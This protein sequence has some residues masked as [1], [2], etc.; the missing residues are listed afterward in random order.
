M[1]KEYS[2]TRGID[3]SKINL[4]P[5]SEQRNIVEFLSHIDKIQ[6]L[7]VI[8][9]LSDHHSK[10][11][12]WEFNTNIGKE[13]KEESCLTTLEIGKSLFNRN[14]E[15]TIIE[16][17]SD[18]TKTELFL[19]K[20][21]IYLDI[22]LNKYPRAAFFEHTSGDNHDPYHDF[23]SNTG[24]I[25]IIN[26]Y[27]PEL[28]S[29]STIIFLNNFLE[30]VLS[31]LNVYISSPKKGTEPIITANLPNNTT[32]RTIILEQLKNIAKIDKQRQFYRD[33]RHHDEYIRDLYGIDATLKYIESLS[34]HR[35][36]DVGA[37][38]GVAI[39]AIA[40][41]HPKLDF[42]ATNLTVNPQLIT[43]LSKDKVTITP[44][45]VMKGF[46]P[47]S[48]AGIIA[49]ASIAY[50]VSPE[51]IVQKF[52]EILVPGGV[53]KATFR[54]PQLSAMKEFGFQ[55]NETFA[56]Y[57]KEVGFDVQLIEK[58]ILI[59]I[60]PENTPKITA[61]K[62]A[63]E[64]YQSYINSGLKNTWTST[65]GDGS[66]IYNIIYPHGRGY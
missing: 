55:T 26:S 58:R 65:C 63:K 20:K 11:Y 64:D 16:K 53:I 39:S 23:V 47:K 43:N 12:K 1:G 13:H 5:Q 29:E 14:P 10:Y 32:N 8:H 4:G 35:V 15:L 45:E 2:V 33:N 22:N 27:H 9:G 61:K 38:F 34:S 59:A 49:V 19:T 60:K 21:R 42:Y 57:F 25:L 41:K 3:F 37:G 50:S 51:L 30:N 40:Q 48:I 17:S 66:E 62:L 6:E 52:N 18:D 54:N 46:K 28:L 36:V 44:A 56:K 7:I 24:R 31:R